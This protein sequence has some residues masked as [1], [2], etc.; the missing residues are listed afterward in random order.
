MSSV[1][2]KKTGKSQAPDTDKGNR[3]SATIPILRHLLLI[4]IEE[5][6]FSMP[7]YNILTK[8][9]DSS[10]IMSVLSN[11]SPFDQT[12]SNIDRSAHE[13]ETA[14]AATEDSATSVTSHLDVIKRWT[15]EIALAARHAGYSAQANIL[16]RAVTGTINLK[17][18]LNF[19]KASARYGDRLSLSPNIRVLTYDIP[20]TQFYAGAID[21]CSTWA[22]QVTATFELNFPLDWEPGVA[23][24]NLWAPRHLLSQWIS[25]AHWIQLQTPLAL[26]MTRHADTSPSSTEA[27][28]WREVGATAC[29]TLI[30]SVS[31]DD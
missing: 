12:T 2:I 8:F 21:A 28:A 30:E 14:M 9:C 27:L 16:L 6:L 13:K 3:G 22:D 23:N 15:Q 25:V 18:A 5:D 4:C 31:F 20:V 10:L 7:A 1:Q 29:R 19:L 17:V 26:A 24:S 11:L